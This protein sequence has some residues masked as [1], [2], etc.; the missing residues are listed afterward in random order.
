MTERT[1][2]SEMLFRLASEGQ[3]HP[4]A[5]QLALAV[6]ESVQF[7]RGTDEVWKELWLSEAAVLAGAVAGH[8][9]AVL[10]KVGDV[11]IH[12]NVVRPARLT[13]TAGDAALALTVDYQP[14]GGLPET[15]ITFGIGQMVDL[16][17]ALNRGHIVYWDWRS[18]CAVGPTDQH[19][20]VAN[21]ASYV[22]SQG[23]PVSKVGRDDAIPPSWP[24]YTRLDP[25]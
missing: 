16:G 8:R 11:F 17:I 13:L 14:D 3:T 6:N 7:G 21:I 22:R 9:I 15:N 5:E 2:E 24:G 25:K 20:D 1:A 12:G 19:P 18:A 4:N 10:G 23:T